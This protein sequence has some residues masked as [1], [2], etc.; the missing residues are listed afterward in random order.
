[1]D[2]GVCRS[3]AARSGKR[4][5]SS[6]KARTTCANR[7]RTKS[8]GNSSLLPLLRL[9]PLSNFRLAVVDEPFERLHALRSVDVRFVDGGSEHLDRLVVG[10]DI[11]GEGRAVLAAMRER[12]SRRIARACGSA[13][14]HLRDQRERAKRPRTDTFH[15]EERLEVLR[16]AIV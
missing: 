13:V 8:G 12:E 1:S 5:T 14:D 2:R 3:S 7:S 9:L 15:S 11:D 4:S 16:G 10:F 6:G